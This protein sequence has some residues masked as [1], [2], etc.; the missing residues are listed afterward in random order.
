[1]RDRL[2]GVS[3]FVEAV[4]SGGFARAAER[5]A[6][7]RS[8]VSKTI[9]RLEARLGVRLFNRTTRTQSLTE[10]GQLYY[11]RCLKA[12]EE[13]RK[14]ESLL[15]SGRREVAGRLRVSMPILFGRYCVAPILVEMAREHPRLELELSFSDQV[16]DIIGERFDLAIR[17]GA[18]GEGSG[19]HGRKLTVQRKVVCAAP[20]YLAKQGRPRT[21]EDM[22]RHDALVYWRNDQLYR[23]FLRDGGGQM[24]EVPLKW[25]VRFDNQEAIADAAVAGLGVAWLPSWLVN[26][27]VEDGRLVTLLDDFPAADLETYAVWPT[28]QYVPL[29]L[30]MAIDLLAQKLP[31][32]A[33]RGL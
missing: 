29:R 28:S 7:T 30:R 20:E 21:I 2:D 15:D 25:R 24:R 6:L 14:A 3:V 8:A 10:D 31:A 5:L 1:M 12:I 26:E 4:E 18:L 23:W 27:H 9:G 19:L 13:L 32:I 22:E 16:V 33:T 17:N 11:E